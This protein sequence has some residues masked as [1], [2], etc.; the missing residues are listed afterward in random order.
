MKGSPAWRGKKRDKVLAKRFSKQNCLQL[1]H[2]SYF[3]S[4]RHSIGSLSASGLVDSHHSYAPMTTTRFMSTHVLSLLALVCGYRTLNR[5]A[6][7][8]KSVDSLR[9]PGTSIERAWSIFHDCWFCHRRSRT[10]LS[11]HAPWYSVLFYSHTFGSHWTGD[12]LSPPSSSCSTSHWWSKNFNPS[13]VNPTVVLTL[14]PS[15][16]TASASLT[17]HIKYDTSREEKH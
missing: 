9:N 8:T 4:S 10:M 11:H 13:G 6:E 12:V 16:C 7:L 15:V 5:G 3:S 1:F 17:C 14:V 2:I